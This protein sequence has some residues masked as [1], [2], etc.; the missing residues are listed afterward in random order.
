[1]MQKWSNKIRA[2]TGSKEKTRRNIVHENVR[3]DFKMF[4][5][6]ESFEK[7]RYLNEN[8]IEEKFILQYEKDLMQP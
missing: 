2:I 5:F 7:D 6:W 1:M 8:D 4:S 3:R